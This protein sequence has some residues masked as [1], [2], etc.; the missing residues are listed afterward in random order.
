MP[1][2]AGMTDSGSA[3]A[4]IIVARQSR[5]NSQTTSTAS[6]APSYKRRM[7]PSYS[8][9]TGVTKLKD[10]VI[11]RS[12]CWALSSSRAR[13]TPAATSSSLAP[14][15]RATSKPTT[16]WP[17]SRAAERRSAMVSVT[18]ATS[19]S[20]MGRPSL[21]TSR[22][23]ASS[24]AVPTVARVRTGC[25]ESPMSVRPP[26]LSRCTWRSWR[27]MS[28]AE[29]PRAWSRWGSSAM[30]ISRVTP[31]TRLTAPTPGTFSSLRA[32]SLSTS[33][34]SASS[35]MLLAR[36]V[37]ASTGW[38]ARSTLLMMGSRRSAGMSARTRDTAERTSSTASCRGFSSSNSAVRLTLPSWIL[39]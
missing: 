30:R 3:T 28:A 33:Q 31:P 16:G 1:A 21:R 20:R 38:P 2:K 9:W 22:R 32:T 6:S 37:K 29:A 15:L 39:V 10:S 11:C 25:S 7:E 19:D 27:E 4:E 12:A 34:D 13:W 23:L 8:S 14:R 17:S 18:E 5:R 35:S 36:T 24:S 26:E